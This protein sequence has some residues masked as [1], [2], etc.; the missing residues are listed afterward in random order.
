MQTG[1]KS[2]SRTSRLSTPPSSSSAR[3]GFVS[4]DRLSEVANKAPSSGRLSKMKIRAS[5]HV[6]H[7]VAFHGD[8]ISRMRVVR[9]FLQSRLR[10]YLAQVKTQESRIEQ[11][12]ALNKKNPGGRRAQGLRSR[13]IMMEE[14]RFLLTGEIQMDAA[15]SRP[16]FSILLSLREKYDLCLAWLDDM[17]ERKGPSSSSGYSGHTVEVLQDKVLRAYLIFDQGEKQA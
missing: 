11:V 5:M 15:F 7:A 16:H 4:S 10:T 8:G 14:A 13:S 1:R 12:M 6:A 2:T 9:G 17:A 3:K